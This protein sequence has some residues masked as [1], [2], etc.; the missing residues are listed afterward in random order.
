ML[1][2]LLTGGL[3]VFSQDAGE[4]LRQVLLLQASEP[5]PGFDLLNARRALVPGVCYEVVLWHK[6]PAIRVWSAPTAKK[7]VR[8]L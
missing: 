3:D 7:K 6:V 1:G 5:N 8:S 2:P 4:H